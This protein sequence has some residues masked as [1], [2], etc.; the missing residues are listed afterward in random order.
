MHWPRTA[1][2][3]T[4]TDI[5]TAADTDAI[6]RRCGAEVWMA[7]A[8]PLVI[9]QLSPTDVGL[10]LSKEPIEEDLVA[11]ESPSRQFVTSGPGD[12]RQGREPVPKREQGFRQAS[13]GFVLVDRD[14]PGGVSMLTVQACGRARQGLPSAVGV[15]P[16]GAD[17]KARATLPH[18]VRHVELRC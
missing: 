14:D 16:R 10:G 5:Q 9:E 4:E 8:Q 2:I 7:E 18:Q 15:R 1:T 17:S 12:E 6:R 11:D 3:A 13:F